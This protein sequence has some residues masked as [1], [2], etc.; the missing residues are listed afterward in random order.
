MKRWGSQSLIMP[1]NDQMEVLLQHCL[2]SWRDLSQLQM[3]SQMGS[4]KIIINNLEIEKGGAL[5][6]RGCRRYAYL[7]KKGLSDYEK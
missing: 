5:M 7:D 1:N 2:V 3:A 6:G 4:L